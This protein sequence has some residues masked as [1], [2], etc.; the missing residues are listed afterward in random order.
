VVF[1][2][3]VEEEKEEGECPSDTSKRAPGR[4]EECKAIEDDL[5]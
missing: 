4:L 2:L 5:R 1:K 3:V